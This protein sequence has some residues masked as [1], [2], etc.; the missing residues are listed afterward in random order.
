MFPKIGS[1]RLIKAQRAGD[2]P[3]GGYSLSKVPGF[4]PRGLLCEGVSEG[5]SSLRCEPQ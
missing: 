4:F 1:V 5:R 2:E 3:V